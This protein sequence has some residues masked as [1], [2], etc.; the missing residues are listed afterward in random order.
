MKTNAVHDAPKKHT[1]KFGTSFPLSIG[2]ELVQTQHRD[3]VINPATEE[4]IA[5][6]SVASAVE[7]DAAVGSASKAFTTWK[8]LCLEHRQKLL[9]QLADKLEE[10]E[11]QFIELL[12]L[13]QGKPQADAEWEIRG[14]IHWLRTIAGQ[15]LDDVE[16]R[17]GE[18]RVTSRH[19]PLGVVAAITPWNFPVLLAVWKIAPALL[20]GNTVV[21]KPSPYTPLCT[22][23]LGELAQQ[24]L[25]PGVLNVISGGNDL[26][27]MLTQ[28]ADIA[29]VAFTGSTETGKHVL[30]STAGTI[31]RV[32]L[33]L[34]G[35]DAAIVLPDADTKAIAGQLF[36]AAFRNNA[37]FCVASKRLYIHESI[38]DAMVAELCKYAASIKI[39]HGDHPDTQLGPLQNRMQYEKVQD[40]IRSSRDSG[41]KLIIACNPPA[42]K[43][44]FVP[45]VLVDNPDD[46]SRCVVE[47]AF[48][49]VLPLLKYKSIDEVVSRANSTRFGLA[50]SVWGQDL[51]QAEAVA[52]RLETGSVWINQI[53][54]FSPDIPFGG[55][56]QS[57]LGIENGLHGLAEYTN[58]QTIL[59][60]NEQSLAR[61]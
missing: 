36:W 39:G 37:Q 51:Q 34:G 53:H 42:G 40:L 21:V 20:T 33:E 38:Y 50:G 23:W 1:A 54:Q 59:I 46:S 15:S 6:T 47:E 5:E 56:K 12:T 45:V 17:I 25:P 57:G 9:A 60:Q 18:Q 28:H 4:V 61:A 19:V 48:G 44:Y 55:H 31:K 58:L 26:G 13:E 8:A 27:Q 52:R 24:L 35:N 3:E 2:G 41:L 16:V 30:R 14:S 29:K 7:L 43:G 10:H 11:A 49:P 32:T 22:L